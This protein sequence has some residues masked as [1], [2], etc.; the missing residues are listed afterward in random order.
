[1]TKKI[2][3]TAAMSQNI[4]RLSDCDYIGIDKGA[5]TAIRAQIPLICAIGD[6]DSVT[7]AEKAEIAAQCPIE[8]LPRHKDETD[9]EKGI[10]YALEHGYDEIILYGGLGGRI[11][12]TTANLYLLMYR[13]LPLTLMDE[14]HC[15]KRL[16]KG[17]HQIPKLFTYLSFLA[18]EKTVI[19]EAGVVYPLNRRMITPKDIYPIS[20][21]II[22]DYAEITIHEGS[23][24]MF[25]CEDANCL[26]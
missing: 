22:S 14:H 12:H 2:M 18:L 24:I 3:L 16:K 10:L 13:D 7:E 4:P 15:I 26:K 17:R 21:E 23:V 19:S 8:T 5:L 25:Q 20:N 1:M 6:F 11:D 9:S